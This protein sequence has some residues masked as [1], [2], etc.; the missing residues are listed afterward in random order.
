MVDFD[1]ANGFYSDL[2]S[3]KVPTF[4]FIAPNQ[5]NDQHGRGNAGAFCNFDPLSDGSQAGLNPALIYRGDVTV[6]RLVTAIKSSPTWKVGHNA[7]VVMWDENDYSTAPNT[8]QVLLIV[9]TNYGVHGVQS[10]QRYTHF[11]LLKSLEAGFGLPCLNHACD[12]S[13]GVM[14]D[15]FGGR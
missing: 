4:S 1:G 8:N 13:V 9:D 2:G 7:I 5:C 10:A 15:L 6:Q 12:S 3:G 14:S 11:S